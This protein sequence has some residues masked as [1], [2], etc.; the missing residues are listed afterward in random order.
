M[1]KNW[2]CRLN[3]V[4]SNDDFVLAWSID[5]LF[6]LLHGYL[7]LVE[8]IVKNGMRFFLFR[9]WFLLDLWFELLIL[10]SVAWARITHWLPMMIR[11]IYRFRN[12]IFAFVQIY[13]NL[14]NYLLW[15]LDDAW[16]IDDWTDLFKKA[17]I[18]ITWSSRL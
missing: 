13:L 15:P 11:V 1:N 16:T 4:R 14:S 6:S 18:I 17:C 5:A 7:N 10:F 2:S 9:C 3:L 12:P 8:L